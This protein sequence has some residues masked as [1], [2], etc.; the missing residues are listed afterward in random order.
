[1]KKNILF[2]VFA[3]LLLGSLLLAQKSNIAIEK[4][5]EKVNE[6]A[7]KQL[8]ESALKEVDVILAQAQK[9]KNS[10]QV[11][12]ALVYKMRFTLEK[13]PDEAPALIR[14]FEV[15]TEK[16]ADP[17][18]RALLHS[19]TA[20]LYAQYY[21][22]DQ[23]AINNR[24]EV[25]GFVPEDM[26]EWT[27]NIYFDKISKH[28]VASLE[29]PT[30]LQKAD[31]LKFSV[32]LLKGDDSRTLQPTLFD[33]LSYRRIQLLQNLWQITALKNPLK[34]P[35]YFSNASDFSVFK[36]D[37]AFKNSTENQVLE[38]YQQLLS[39]RLKANN[40]P[41]LLYAD[42]QRLK[43]AKQHSGVE[44]SDSLYL[45]ALSSLERQFADNE[46]VVEVLAEKAN[47]YL[48]KQLDIKT[49]KRNAY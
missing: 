12:K 17:A 31:A 20:E 45:A 35:V 36:Q 22:K 16:S 6:L 44:N 14:D 15:F 3:T 38:T 11:I 47:Y 4:R 29:N 42:L 28:L 43:Y 5:W 33:F 39:F 34:D 13:N 8:P 30:V 10:V 9:E 40:V 32:L 1:M 2:A 49:F 26:K 23:W 7:D 25:S 19:M 24:T 46:A 27:K 48:E 41:A 18:E 37:S 21:Q